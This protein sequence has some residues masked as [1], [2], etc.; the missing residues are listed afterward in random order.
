MT[1][2]LTTPVDG[3]ER[4]ELD[5]GIWG[6]K[7]MSGLIVAI[8]AEDENVT[9]KFESED[10]G[11]G[12]IQQKEKTFFSDKLSGALAEAVGENTHL[13]E[14][15]EMRYHLMNLQHGVRTTRT[16]PIM[17]EVLSFDLYKNGN[18]TII[19][20][21]NFDQSSIEGQILLDGIKNLGNSFNK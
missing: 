16:I 11:A 14:Q 8:E 18:D 15:D 1:E 9:T 2:K 5:K 10:L 3:M 21:L 19:V 13:L 20:P 12:V 7:D 6:Y 17:G 4:V